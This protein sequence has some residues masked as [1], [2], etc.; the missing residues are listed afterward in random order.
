MLVRVLWI[1]RKGREYLK[2]VPETFGW[3][4][5]AI[6]YGVFLTFYFVLEYT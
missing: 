3:I 2:R 1:R 4:L 6:M 5:R